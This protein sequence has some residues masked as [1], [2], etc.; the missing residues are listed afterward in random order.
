MPINREYA[1]KIYFDKLPPDLK[2]K[3]PHGVPFTGTGHPDFTRY[4]R[5]R[6]E[7][8]FSGNTDRDIRMANKIMG[9]KGE[10]NNFT[11]HHH[12]DGKTMLLI[13]SKLHDS[14]RHTGGSAIARGTRS[15]K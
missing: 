7:I 15:S 10:P 11:W 13:D 8:R 2:I 1:G 3:Y 6:V 12:H 14:V 5:A 9:W 4:A